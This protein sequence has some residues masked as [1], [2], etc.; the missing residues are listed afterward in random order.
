MKILLYIID[1][2]S[3]YTY[4]KCKYRLYVCLGASPDDKMRKRRGWAAIR[5]AP[6]NAA[7]TLPPPAE[8]AGQIQQEEQSGAGEATDTPLYLHRSVDNT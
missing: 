5:T 2:S 6:K 4:Y 3:N 7:S 8:A 1:Y